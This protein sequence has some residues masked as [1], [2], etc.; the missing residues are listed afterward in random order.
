GKKG[1]FAKECRVGSSYKSQQSDRVDK[2]KKKES[3]IACW[4]DEDEEEQPNEVT[5]LALMAKSDFT[6]DKEDEVLS[7]ASNDLDYGD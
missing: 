4:S 3:F 6:S 7:Y 2:G 5:N 1:H